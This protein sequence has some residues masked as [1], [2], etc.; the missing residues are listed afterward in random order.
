[1]KLTSQPTALA[2]VATALLASASPASVHPHVFAEA[3]LNVGLS[4][5]K[6][7]VKTLR[8]LWRFDELFSSTVMMEFDKN[9][10]LQLDAAEMQAV[11]ETIHASLADYNYFQ[12]VT[13]DGKDI[14]MKAPASLNVQFDND[15][16]V[17][18]FE[19]EP[20][21]PL[22]LSGKVD[23]GVYDPTFYTAIDFVTDDKIAVDGLP[24]SCERTVLR[25]SAE[26]AIAQNQSKLT[27]AFF[28]DPTGTNMAKIFATKLELNC[29]A[30]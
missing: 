12:I 19:S 10:D 17:V 7:T 14:P 1:M 26:D 16:L 23:F 20:K 6:T 18:S 8:H 4:T 22:T 2:G 25:P 9:S 11:S 30:S 3:Q 21:T 24:S 28:N 27:D 15:Q 13:V 29:K 5:D